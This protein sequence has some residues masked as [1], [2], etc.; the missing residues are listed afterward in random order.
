VTEGAEGRNERLWSFP[1]GHAGPADSIKGF[2]VEAADGHAGNVSWA[3]YAPGE[4]Y[5]VVNHV[6]HL[7]EVH[8]V[9]PAGAVESV[10]KNDHS[11]ALR[12]TSDD[13]EELPEHH[14]PAAPVESW[15]VEAIDRATGTWSLG[16]DMY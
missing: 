3:S 14:E 13:V 9:V 2:Q 1:E 15:M 10:D 11:V 6:H 16:G 7:H 8:H 4:S 12:L 5:L